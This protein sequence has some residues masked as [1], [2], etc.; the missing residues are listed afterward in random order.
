VFIAVNLDHPDQ[1]AEIVAELTATRRVA[2]TA[3]AY[4]YNTA[5]A[6]KPGCDPAPYAAAGATWWL[7]G[8]AADA[9][10]A[11]HRAVPGGQILQRRDEGDTRCQSL[12]GC[13][14]LDAE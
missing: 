6:V 11:Q 13:H 7:V 10:R 2:G 12:A 1:L 14:Y 8:V 4:P 3:D 9:A 5:V